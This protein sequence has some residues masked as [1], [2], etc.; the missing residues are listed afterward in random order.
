MFLLLEVPAYPKAAGKKSMKARSSCPVSKS[1]SFLCGPPPLP[2]PC[3]FSLLVSWW[4]RDKALRGRRGSGELMKPQVYSGTTL[5]PSWECNDSL[6]SL[7]SPRRTFQ[8]ATV[9]GKWSL[10][11]SSKLQT[12]SQ[13]QGRSL[14]TWPV[15]EM[16]LCPA[17]LLFP[18]PEW[19]V[20]VKHLVH[21][22]VLIMC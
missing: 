22:D 9:R 19:M 14:N 11:N 15:P 4:V 6:S 13:V 18:L 2:V 12:I 5:P 8:E 3:S 21:C 1:H 20:W 7:S 10:N 17:T 16:K